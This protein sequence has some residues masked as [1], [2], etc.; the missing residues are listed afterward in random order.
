ME[1]ITLEIV[2]LI[3]SGG[4][5][6]QHLRHL[7]KQSPVTVLAG[8]GQ[9]APAEGCPKT[10]LVKLFA[11]THQTANNI[12]QTVTI[13]K[14]SKTEGEKMIIGR[15]IAGSSFGRKFFYTTSKLTWIKD[16]CN[17]RKKIRHAAA[18]R[19]APKVKFISN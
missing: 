9:T 18:Y 12:S 6:H 4:S 5:S 14:L 16:R 3:K 19:T 8:I 11:P 15:K 7:E 2:G 17:L 1:R 10:H 13:G